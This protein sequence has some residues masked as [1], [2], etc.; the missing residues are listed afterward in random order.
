MLTLSYLCQLSQAFLLSE[1]T[2]YN[3]NPNISQC[4]VQRGCLQ[5]FPPVYSWGWFLWPRLKEVAAWLV[6]PDL[7]HLTRCSCISWNKS[8]LVFALKVFT[9]ERRK[10]FFF[11]SPSKGQECANPRKRFRSFSK[12]VS[13]IMCWAEQEIIKSKRRMVFNY[14]RKNKLKVLQWKKT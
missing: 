2:T 7:H 9:L 10:W 13:I 1:S 4:H 12:T 5:L 8:F 3:W 6:P 14:F 11:F